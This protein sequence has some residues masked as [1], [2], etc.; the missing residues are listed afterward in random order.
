M[1]NFSQFWSI[2]SSN[3]VNCC[4]QNQN[5][6]SYQS[7]IGLQTC[8]T[9]K[10]LQKSVVSS[11]VMKQDLK[12]IMTQWWSCFKGLQRSN[13]KA[14]KFCWIFDRI[15]EQSASIR[16]NAQSLLI[17]LSKIYQIE[18][19]VSTSY[20]NL[21]NFSFSKAHFCLAVLWTL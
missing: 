20:Q 12:N 1:S 8:H 4:Q 21:V 14:K 19:V 17:L 6:C 5:W 18:V 2:S 10:I 3:L 9:Y 13:E 11:H 16:L 7:K 15:K